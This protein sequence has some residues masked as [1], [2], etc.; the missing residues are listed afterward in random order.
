MKI[1]KGSSLLN[2]IAYDLRSSAIKFY[3][4]KYEWVIDKVLKETLAYEWND[5]SLSEVI[6]DVLGL[7]KDVLSSVL[8]EHEDSLKGFHLTSLNKKFIIKNI[9]N[10]IVVKNI[11][12][13]LEVKENLAH[14]LYGHGVCSIINPYI[15]IN[16]IYYM[17]NGITYSS[18]KKE[19]NRTAN[20]GF[21]ELFASLITKDKY[22]KYQLNKCTYP[23]AVEVATQIF[24]YENKEEIIKLMVEGKGDISKIFNFDDYS[25][26][27]ELSNLLELSI[28]DSDYDDDIDEMIDRYIKRKKYKRG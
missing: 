22:P 16:G 10:I 5:E 18:N 7:P 15:K 19:I 11:G 8:L 17:R 25:N 4:K 2:D 1:L 21:I 27:Y 3:G 14:E 6:N 26:W 13:D 23:K 28:E 9:K 20:E 24:K 12:E